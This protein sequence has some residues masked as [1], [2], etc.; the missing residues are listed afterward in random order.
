[1]STLGGHLKS[2]GAAEAPGW[3]TLL[4]Y[5]T[6]ITVKNMD[7]WNFVADVKSTILALTLR[8]PP[9]DSP[10]ANLSDVTEH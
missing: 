10:L 7:V 5:S 1:M 3:T 4:V 8:K 6:A 9:S 2:A